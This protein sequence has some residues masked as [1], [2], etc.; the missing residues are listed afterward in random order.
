MIAKK[1]LTLTSIFQ[2]TF[3]ANSKRIFFQIFMNLT[4][5][6]FVIKSYLQCLKLKMFGFEDDNTLLVKSFVSLFKH[7]V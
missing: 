3:D 6:K 5:N 1:I 2:L 4:K 7:D